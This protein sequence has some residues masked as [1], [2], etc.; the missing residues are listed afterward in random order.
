MWFDGLVTASIYADLFIARQFR[1]RRYRPEAPSG[2]S[3][4]E[5][6]YRHLSDPLEQDN[7]LVRRDDGFFPVGTIALLAALHHG[8]LF[9]ALDAQGIDRLDADAVASIDMLY[10]VGDLDFIGV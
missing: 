8:A 2:A 1:E 7:R 3:R 10:S 9:L 5:F 4:F 6:S